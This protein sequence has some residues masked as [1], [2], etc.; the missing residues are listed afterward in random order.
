MK[1]GGGGVVEDGECG[2]NESASIPPLPVKASA[3]QGMERE[4]EKLEK[5]EWEMSG[6]KEGVRDKL[7]EKIL[8]PLELLQWSI[9][10][11]YVCPFTS[12][13]PPTSVQ[14]LLCTQQMDSPNKGND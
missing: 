2:Q 3:A 4:Q 10:L 7:V 6:W 8:N 14:R 1:W 9:T 12:S 11:P 5:I 13:P